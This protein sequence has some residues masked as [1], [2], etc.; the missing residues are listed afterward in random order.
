MMT[1]TELRR[2]VNQVA[3]PVEAPG[4]ILIVPWG[5]V[6]SASG[7]F[8][9][10]HAS[11]A[12]MIAAHTG[13]GVDLPIDYEHETL[14]GDYAAPSGIAP[15][16]GWVKSLEVEAGVGVWANVEWTERGAGYVRAKEYRYLSPVVMVRKT[17]RRAVELHSIALTNKPAIVDMRPIV[18]SAAGGDQVTT[19]KE[20]DMRVITK[21]LGLA[22]GAD[23]AAC[24]AAI[25]TL[26]EARTAAADT[27]VDATANT[28]RTHRLEAGATLSGATLDA[29]PR[30][31]FDA[32]ANSLRTANETLAALQTRET[33]RA[34]EERIA[35]A[36]REGRLT[37]EMLTPDANGANHW[38]S[39][40]RDGAAW[41]AC[42]TRMPVV[43]PPA[44]RV[45]NKA[46]GGVGG[47]VGGDRATVIARASA[48]Y[49]AHRG[50]REMISCKS[51]W[52]NDALREGKLPPLSKDEVV[53]VG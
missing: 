43:A 53:A 28:A 14:G 36:Q 34:A 41:T 21:A 26:Q 8:L 35:C 40:A 9:C 30:A 10:D 42:M 12:A 25:T 15:A 13:H 51:A 39:L 2:A 16:A 47:G 7:D 23:E 38:R 32:V 18:N 44:G 46:A 49:E 20:F 22:D 1:E 3:V 48:E 52:I 31:E 33:D 50:E 24:V 17:D 29:V 11:A 5:A 19:P 6:R 37:D 45:V 27:E 4:R